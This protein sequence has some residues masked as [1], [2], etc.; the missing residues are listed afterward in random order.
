[1]RSMGDLLA[2]AD[3][4]RFLGSRGVVIGAEGFAEL[5]RPPARPGLADLFGLAPATRLVYVAH[6]THADLRRSVGSKFRAARDLRADS[7]TSVALWL[8]MDRAG[9]DK[10]STTITWPLPD[11]KA[12]VRLV[13]QRLRDLEP[14]FLPVER[15]RLEEVTEAIGG[16]I[17]L[18][19]GDPDRRARAKERLEALAQAIVG[20]EDATTLARTNLALVSFLLRERFGFQP[21]GALVSTIAS[22][23]LLTDTINDCLSE[24]DDVVGVFNRAVEDLIAADVDPVVHQLDDAYLPLHY[25]CDRCGARRR[26]RRERAGSDTF[27]VLAC[28]CGEGRRFHLGDRA[29][30]L[31][32]LEAT[33]RWSVDVTLPVYLNDLASGVVAGRSSALYGLVLREVLEKVLGRQA[34]PVMLPDDLADS[35]GDDAVAD[36]ALYGYLVGT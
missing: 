12:S 19:V 13:P 23:G 5:L 11:G 30:S 14:R 26:L 28:T 15:S 20:E 18:A 2:G 1:M 35:L 31:G 16:W 9:S 3:G 22:L 34:I 36:S 8:D 33:E 6:Q 32:E 27:A 29:L 10:A 21:P 7:L 4:R 25:S 24:I 17:D